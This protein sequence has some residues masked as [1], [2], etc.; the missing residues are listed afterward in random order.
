MKTSCP[1]ALDRDLQK[2]SMRPNEIEINA[3]AILHPTISVNAD[4]LKYQ[5]SILESSLN[6]AEPVG[7]QKPA[8]KASG[9]KEKIVG[10]SY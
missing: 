4:D 10:E 8:P 6:T 1:D 7:V 2:E 5:L 9:P 3:A